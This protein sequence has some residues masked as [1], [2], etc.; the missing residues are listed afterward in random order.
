MYSRLCGLGC[1]L[2]RPLGLGDDTGDQKLG[3]NLRAKCRLNAISRK[4]EAQAMGSPLSD[5]L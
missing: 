1:A 3:I 4:T 5:P 2:G